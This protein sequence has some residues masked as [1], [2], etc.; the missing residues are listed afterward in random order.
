MTKIPNLITKLSNE[1]KPIEPLRK[2]T[3]LTLKLLAALVF[4]T[5]VLQIF[6]GL[7]D[8][9][10]VQITRP[11]FLAEIGLMF[12][13]FFTAVLAA[14]LA[15]YP[16]LY[17]KSHLLKL[18]YVILFFLSL[19][20]AAQFFLPIDER[21]ILPQIVT[22]QMMC[23]SCILLLSLAPAA[24]IFIILQKGATLVAMQSGIFTVL[25]ASALGCL[26]LRLSEMNDSISHL[27]IWHYLPIIFFS[28]IGALFGRWL[29]KW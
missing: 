18:P 15:M 5:V 9:L 16:D 1:I 7:R 2:P 27:L 29:L 4:Y 25:A 24:L 21:M 10:F 14:V 20:L 3:S 22:H 13:L 23:T 6:L 11:L 17:Q 12:L 8:D 26:M 19:I 28:L